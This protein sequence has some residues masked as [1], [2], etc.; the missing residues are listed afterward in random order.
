MNFSPPTLHPSFVQN[1][2]QRSFVRQQM[3]IHAALRA[4]ATGLPVAAD[5]GVAIPL[6]TV[7]EQGSFDAWIG[8]QFP[9][10]G[11]GGT[12]TLLVDFGSS[13][14]IIPNGENRMATLSWT[15]FP[16]SSG[17]PSFRER[18]RSADSSPNGRERPVPA[19]RG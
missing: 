19:G 9:T 14:M 8:V 5:E 6:T 16:I 2:A 10:P 12:A 17:W 18:S 15:S 11:G 1:E 13:T 4:E 3:H 7:S